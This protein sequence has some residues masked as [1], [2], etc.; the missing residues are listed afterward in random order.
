MSS[1]EPILQRF[2]R[3]R[4][5]ARLAQFEYGGMPRIG[6]ENGIATHCDDL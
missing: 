2:E 6:D 5:R 4:E 1:R 3:T